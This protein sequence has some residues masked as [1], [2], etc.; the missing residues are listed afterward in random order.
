MSV[1]AGVFLLFC[2]AFC[3]TLSACT[4]RRVRPRRVP[5]NPANP[6]NPAGEERSSGAVAARP[7]ATPGLGPPAAWE[8]DPPDCAAFGPV[9]VALSPCTNR[10]G[11]GP[12]VPSAT[13]RST[14]F[15]AN[16]PIMMAGGKI[17]IAVTMDAIRSI[18][19]PQTGPKR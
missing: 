3:V 16:I 15:I 13:L 7:E 18:E 5:A 17:N 8:S 11:G 12:W 4:R 10:S 14:L 2:V 9:G 6:A 19:P 1:V